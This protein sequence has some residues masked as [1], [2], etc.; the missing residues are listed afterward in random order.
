M[1]QKKNPLSR[2]E[3]SRHDYDVDLNLAM[4]AMGA[5]NRS[6]CANQC[7]VLG[8][9]AHADCRRE[10]DKAPSGVTFCPTLLF[11]DELATLFCAA[12][13]FRQNATG[14]CL[15]AQTHRPLANFA[16]L[17]FFRD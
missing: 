3:M 16:R 5:Q 11:G 12:A 9:C 2:L 13:F 10:E 7:H 14:T 8:G 4:V 6:K 17:N 1:I 15:V